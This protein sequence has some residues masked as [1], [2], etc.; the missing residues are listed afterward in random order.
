MAE[1]M[2]ILNRF[3]TQPK[4]KSADPAVRAAGVQ[5]ISEEEQELLASIA[6]TD[7]DARVRRAAVS[8]LGTVAVLAEMVRSDADEGVRDE[9]AGVLLDIALG[10]YEADEPASRAAV[11]ALAQLPGASAQKHLLLVAKTAKRESVSR[12]ALAGLQADPKALGSVARRAELPAIRLEA[13]AALDD[14][15]ELQATALRSSFR[16][17]SV[18]ALER[19]ASDRAALKTVATRGANPAAVRRARSLL[20]ALEEADAAEAAREKARLAALEAR[21]RGWLDLIREVEQLASHAAAPDA[22]DR[23]ARSITRWGA[24][25]AEVDAGVGQRFEAA[26][27]STQEALERAEAE[28]AAEAQKQAAVE[29]ALA[30]RKALVERLE[31]L[32]IDSAD[33][34]GT[35]ASAWQAL[36]AVDSPGARELLS[37]FDAAVRRLERQGRDRAALAER[38][39]RLTDLATALEAVI[40]DERYPGA[41]ELRQRSRRLQQDWTS[42]AAGLEQEPSASEALARGRA[43]EAALA[44]RE[45]HWR[46]QRAAESDEHR[47]RAQ[48]AIQRMMDLQKAESPTLKS[49][50]RAITEAISAETALEPLPADAARDEL[51]ARLQAAR[52]ELQP[53]AQALREADDWQRWANATVQERL[54]GEM[55]ALGNEADAAAAFKRMRDLT[56]EW[57][58]VAAAPRDRAE[59][60]WNRFRAAADVVRARFEPIRAQQS[61]EQADH[62]AR[63]IALCEKAEALATSTD[64]IHTADALKALQAEWKTIGPAPRREEQAVWERFRTACNSFF[65]RRQDD[66]KQRKDQW[67]ENLT[68]KEALISRAEA[69][70]EAQDPEAAFAELKTLQAEWRTIGPVKKSKSEQVWQ[71][72]R[73]AADKVF[74]RY[75]NRDAQALADRVGRRESIVSELEAL[76]AEGNAAKARDGLLEKVRSLRTGWQQAGTVPREAARVL[77]ERYERAL[78]AIAASAPDAFRHTELDIQANRKQLEALCERVERLA[79]KETP[80][81]TAESP[82]ELLA[83]QLREALAANTIGG[84]VD[85]ETKWKTSEYEVRAAQDAWRQVGFVPEAEAAPLTV[86]FQRACQ[87]FYGQRRGPAGPGPGHGPGPRGPR[88]GGPPRPRGARPPRR[89]PQP[90]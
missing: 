1:A 23:L 65:T 5:E 3:K 8:K 62:L 27:A 45:Q 15:A 53:K 14:P 84:R 33:E 67:S 78:G 90:H 85:E 32:G 88:S 46:D 52:T 31:S 42:A 22:A 89:E 80:A 47:R 11:E 29:Q 79:G 19:I 18:G 30:E 2:G 64:W 10:A 77:T 68:K 82:A 43:A 12:A 40:A 83:H 60:L 35:I 86:R 58:T 26:V 57:K 38:V 28:R 49:L 87:R 17:A 48:Q 69:L 59:T 4:W 70:G 13:L 7:D 51:L 39:K 55:D 6:R 71:R 74:D 75:R 37:R 63:K 50:E 73:A 41:R 56:A 36:P 21:R 34:Q 72:F 9:A 44:E 16:D 54:I 61:A 24:E 25:A 66:L 81:A 20:R 76:A